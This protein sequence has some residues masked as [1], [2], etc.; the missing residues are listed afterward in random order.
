MQDY[1][2]ALILQLHRKSRNKTAPDRQSR[3]FCLPSVFALDIPASLCIRPACFFSSLLQTPARL[4]Y[5]EPSKRAAPPLASSP[6]DAAPDPDLPTTSTRTS[7]AQ[8]RSHL[9]PYYPPP[10]NPRTYPSADMGKYTFTWFVRACDD[11]AFALADPR[12]GN[13]RPITSM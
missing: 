11:S 3:L 1:R 12:A 2:R 10:L 6:L 9:F 13:I 8:D 7:C 5:P 4:L